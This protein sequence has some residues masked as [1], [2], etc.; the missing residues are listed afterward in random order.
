M[1]K[2]KQQDQK[3]RLAAVFASFTILIM[4]AA[5]LLETM[6]L[7]YFSVLGTLEKVIPA[8]IV[9]ASLG[10]VMGLILDKPKKRHQISYNN[11]FLNEVVK[12]VEQGRASGD[13][14][15][16]EDEPKIEEQAQEL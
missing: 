3:K 15:D 4:G 13:S 2:K 8:S 5:S 9:M 7:D 1:K 12:N 6:S 14:L 10:W 11:M 16:V